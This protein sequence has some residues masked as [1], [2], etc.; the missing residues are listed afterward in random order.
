MNKQNNNIN[1]LERM[2]LQVTI[3]NLN[4]IVYKKGYCPSPIWLYIYNW[5]T[6]IFYHF[7][8]I[9]QLIYASIIQFN[10]VFYH[11]VQILQLIYNSINEVFHHFGKMLQLFYTSINEVFHHF[12]YI[13]HMIYNSNIYI[14]SCR[15]IYC[16]YGLW[17]FPSTSI[18]SIGRNSNGESNTKHL[19][20][21]ARARR[22]IGDKPSYGWDKKIDDVYHHINVIKTTKN[23]TILIQIDV[24]NNGRA[25]I[26]TVPAVSDHYV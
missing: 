3:R 21:V 5:F 2:L 17:N 8:Y 14:T 23:K 22:V 1:L 26:R 18:Y 15:A 16:V 7:G 13:L 25:V 12:G 9:L 24:G 20:H 19:N 11:Y 6:I 4:N 10:E